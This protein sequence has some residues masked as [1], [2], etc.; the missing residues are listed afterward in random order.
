MRIQFLGAAG[1]VTGSRIVFDH[2]HYRGM[3]DCGLFQGPKDLRLRNWSQQP[4]IDGI[5]SVL[6]THA[7][8]DHSGYLPKIVKDGFQGA[9]CC[10][11][12]TK[13]LLPVM[14][15]DAAKLQEEDARFANRTQYSNHNPALPLYNES[16]VRSTLSQVKS[17]DWSSW[18]VLQ[19]GLGFRFLN[20]GHILGSSCLQLSFADNNQS[21]ILTFSGDLGGEHG[22]LM[23]PPERILETDYLVIESTYGD[24]EL[25]RSNVMES[26]GVVVNRVIGRGGT[27]IIPAFSVGRTQDLLLLLHRLKKD[28]IVPNVPVYLDSPM[29]HSVTEIYLKH[30]NELRDGVSPYEVE[31]ALSQAVCR[32]VLSADESMLLC[33][34]TEPKI[35]ISASGMLQGGRILH[36]LKMKLPD[37]K[38]GVLFVGYQSLGSKGRVLKD[39]T[40]T[41]RIHHKE[42]DVEAEIISIDGFSAH[43]DSNELMRWMQNFKR[44]PKKVWI[45]H[46]DPE[47][48]LRLLYRIQ[49]ELGWKAQVAELDQ[50]YVCS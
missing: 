12:P 38:S 40:Q 9:I 37:E 22:F 18:N 45:N 43:A 28:K 5:R 31:E 4:L 25:E 36:H 41:L 19:S 23:P 20:A 11:H 8:I 26:L 29:S 14:L 47:A 33:M 2:H 1:T 30:Q 44:S 7:H 6:L 48:S 46:G 27:L 35:V 24:R 50:E 34:S 17:F 3:V 10:T 15:F 32:P 13:D 42:V 39:G 49:T 21:Q 16:D